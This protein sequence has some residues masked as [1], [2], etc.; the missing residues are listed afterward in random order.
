MDGG[1]RPPRLHD[2]VSFPCVSSVSVIDLSQSSELVGSR[3][4]GPD[5]ARPPLLLL[6]VPVPVPVLTAALRRGSCEASYAARRLA[7]WTPR[8]C[9]QELPPLSN[10]PR[11]RSGPR[12]S[13]AAVRA[14]WETVAMAPVVHLLLVGTR[15]LPLAGDAFDSTT[16]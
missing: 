12:A 1:A 2:S 10:G 16:A 14:S 15:R 4:H 5:Y 3:L 8:S 13:E 11:H 6:S 7:I 9:R